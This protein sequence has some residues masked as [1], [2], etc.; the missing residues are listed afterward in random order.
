MHGVHYWRLRWEREAAAFKVITSDITGGQVQR[1]GAVVN[2]ACRR[3]LGLLDVVLHYTVMLYDLWPGSCLLE[4]S[5][6][7]VCILC[8]E[9]AKNS[10]TYMSD[11]RIM[12]FR[13]S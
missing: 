7:C 5:A 11:R 10:H 13:T 9:N 4:H 6:Q 1:G 3:P 2:A 12:V 8:T